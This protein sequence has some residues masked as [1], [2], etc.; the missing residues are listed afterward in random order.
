M[1]RD[2]AAEYQRRRELAAERGFTGPDITRAARGRA[3]SG[4]LTSGAIRD[5]ERNPT[6]RPVTLIAYTD[7]KGNGHVIQVT[8][9]AKGRAKVKDLRVPSDRLD[10]LMDQLDDIVEDLDIETYV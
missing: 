7:A 9:D 3:T 4:G 2:Y 10:D 1:A 5:L 6:D 8:H